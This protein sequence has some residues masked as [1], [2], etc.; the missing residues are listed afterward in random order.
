MD[1][2]QLKASIFDE[3]TIERFKFVMLG[4][5]RYKLLFGGLRNNLFRTT[6]QGG[7]ISALF[8]SFFSI[9][10]VGLDPL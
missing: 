10:K 2:L 7:F 4:D 9:E 5:D 8:L 1:F 3:F 6:F